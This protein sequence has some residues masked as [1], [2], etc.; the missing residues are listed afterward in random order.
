MKSIRGG[1]RV[2]FS[3]PCLKG[4]LKPTLLTAI[5]LFAFSAN[6]SP[7]DP[8][9]GNW[10]TTGIASCGIDDVRAGR[11]MSIGNR[12]LRYGYVHCVI[13]TGATDGNHINI[14]ARCD[15]GGGYEASLTYAWVLAGNDIATLSH[16]GTE[17]QL[18]RCGEGIE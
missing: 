9:K 3:P 2:G 11:I 18:V 16:E 17:V 7:W 5:G 8:I 15:L 10:R 14:E 12:S 13:E 1:R 6:A 4:G